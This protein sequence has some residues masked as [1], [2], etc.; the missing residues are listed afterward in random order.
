MRTTKIESSVE[1]DLDTLYSPSKWV[2]RLDP[3]L[4]VSSHIH[5]CEKFQQ[6]FTKMYYATPITYGT[7]EEYLNFFF[8]TETQKAQ[9][10]KNT[11]AYEGKVIVFVHGGY[12]SSGVL[13]NVGSFPAESFLNDA[14][15]YC[16][17][18]YK[19]S[20]PNKMEKIAKSM[21]NCLNFLTEKFSAAKLILIGH[22][23]GSHLISW[24]LSQEEYINVQKAVLISGIYD[25]SPIKN[26]CINEESKLKLTDDDVSL[27]SPSNSTSNYSKHIDTLICCGEHDSPAFQSQTEEYFQQLH[28][29]GVSISKHILS[30]VDHFSIIESLSSRDS[31]LTT[32][33]KSNKS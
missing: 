11:L 31:V 14:T 20:P 10:L 4:A 32:L 15:V 13:E 19:L 24:C 18:E 22:S 28:A 26:C 17:V 16:T 9:I 6:K 7:K 1:F 12:W 30:G 29:S 3:A 8:Y 27:F 25:L 33:I 2:V 21:Q 5:F 23:A